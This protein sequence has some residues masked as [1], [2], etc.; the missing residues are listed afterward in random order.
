MD[1]VTAK[2]FENLCEACFK[3]KS[4]MKAREELNKKD[5]QTLAKMHAKVV[6]YMEKYNKEK[7]ISESGT[8]SMQEKR[9]VKLPVGDE[10]VKFFNYLKVK[11]IFEGMVSVNSKTFNSFYKAEEDAHKDDPAWSMPGVEMPITIKKIGTYPRK[12]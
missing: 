2:E 5:G 10:K 4:T 9:S 8:L 6:F 1:E 12:G 3:L 11:G 7:H